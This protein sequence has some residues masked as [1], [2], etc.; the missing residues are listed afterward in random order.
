MTDPV[1]QAITLIADIDKTLDTTRV[2]LGLTKTSEEALKIKTCIDSLLDQR[3]VAMR[4][5]DGLPEGAALK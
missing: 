4:V 1:Q 2:L 5:R 3:G